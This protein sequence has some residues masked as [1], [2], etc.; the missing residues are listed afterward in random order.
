MTIVVCSKVWLGIAKFY[1]M[2]QMHVGSDAVFT[3][4]II[5]HLLCRASFLTCICGDGCC[6]CWGGRAV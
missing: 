5:A 1:G 2:S 6:L 4:L 3:V